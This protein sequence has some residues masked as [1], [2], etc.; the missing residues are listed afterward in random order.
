MK[1]KVFITLF[2]ILTCSL[3]GFGGWKVYQYQKI[4]QIIIAQKKAWEEDCKEWLKIV[5]E[6]RVPALIGGYYKDYMNTSNCVINE[7]KKFTTKEQLD[8][9][10]K[11]IED[12]K[13]LEDYVLYY[14]AAGNHPTNMKYSFLIIFQSFILNKLNNDKQY[15][16]INPYQI[17][18]ELEDNVI[19]SPMCLYREV[20]KICNIES[21]RHIKG[22]L[23][24]TSELVYNFFQTIT[25]DQ[26][27]LQQWMKEFYNLIQLFVEMVK[28]DDI[29]MDPIYSDLFMRDWGVF[30]VMNG[31][32]IEEVSEVPKPYPL[33]FP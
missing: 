32:E 28:A 15:E 17:N 29:L 20:L 22:Q 26:P 30:R 25:N 18:C 23:R 16:I 8:I 11:I 3:L 12:M 33:P 10:L 31:I 19:E 5:A 7:T 24:H 4:Q 14:K 27:T 6:V 1:K 13:E 21:R 9:Y 2:A